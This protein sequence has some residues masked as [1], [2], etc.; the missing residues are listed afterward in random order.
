MTRLTRGL[1]PAA[2]IGPSWLIRRRVC[3]VVHGTIWLVGLDPARVSASTWANR[4]G[5]PP[6]CGAWSGWSP[7]EPGAGG[8]D[9]Q[10]RIARRAVPG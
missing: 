9:S 4:L 5:H 6:A 1:W 3:S 10:D 7:P 2:S 8:L